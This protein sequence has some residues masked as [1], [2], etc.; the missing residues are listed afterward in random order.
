MLCFEGNFKTFFFTFE[1]NVG[2]L[3]TLIVVL[4]TKGIIKRTG[5][6]V[7]LAEW[8]RTQTLY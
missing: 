1:L 3:L 5:I 6:Y 2:L 7:D 8:T 4:L